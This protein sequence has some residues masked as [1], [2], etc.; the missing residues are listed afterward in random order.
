MS[1]QTIMPEENIIKEISLTVVPPNQYAVILDIVNNPIINEYS[2]PLSKAVKQICYKVMKNATEVVQGFIYFRY[3]TVM[4]VHYD[5][6]ECDAV[7]K[8][9]IINKDNVIRYLERKYIPTYNQTG[10]IFKDQK[11]I[12]S[13]YVDDK[14]ITTIHIKKSEP[15]KIIT[16]TIHVTRL[17]K[18]QGF[19]PDGRYKFIIDQIQIC[20]QDTLLY[21]LCLREFGF[22][23]PEAAKIYEKQL[24]FKYAK[25]EEIAKI[26]RRSIKRKF[27]RHRVKK[28]E[29]SWQQLRD[30]INITD[31][32]PGNIKKV[33]NEIREDGK[34]RGIIIR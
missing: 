3:R 14:G 21:N 12:Q 33:C 20:Y 6:D 11:C 25:L 16:D 31:F 26:Q 4:K 32:N 9:M 5:E 19:K 2:M 13:A 23:V 30:I 29:I 10:A 24:L 1:S 28:G 17:L 7:L 18:N 8:T 15:H 34:L 22:P 27:L